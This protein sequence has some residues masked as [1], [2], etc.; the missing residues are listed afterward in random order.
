MKQLLVILTMVLL[1]PMALA[2]DYKVKPGDVL[3][4]E[5]LE[6]PSLNRQVLVLPDGR[7]S[8]PM[9]GTLKASGKSIPEVKSALS[10]AMAS[11]FVTPP[12]VFVGLSALGKPKT[13][14]GSGTVEVYVL[15]EVGKPGKY[16][17]N[18]GTTILQFIAEMGGLSKFAATKRIQVWSTDSAG[19]Q[20]SYKFNYNALS[21][22]AGLSNNRVI[23]NGDTVVV[24]QRRLFE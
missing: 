11:N 12:T 13:S 17:I 5:V 18:R 23:R 7:V 20:V 24:P 10:S 3:Q 8:F 9:A 21:K 15:G 1:A 6:D 22:G 2:Q 14:G 19:R 16:K 4:I